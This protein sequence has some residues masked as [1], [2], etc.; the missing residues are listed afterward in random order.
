MLKE[1][2]GRRGGDGYDLPAPPPP[3]PVSPTCTCAS[4]KEC[5]D[6][7]G[8]SENKKKKRNSDMRLHF[9]IHCTEHI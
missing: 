7:R 8:V 6:E 1:C 9:K 3:P 4:L 5:V 2:W